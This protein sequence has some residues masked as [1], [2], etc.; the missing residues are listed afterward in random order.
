[1]I[2]TERHARLV[3]GT[4]AT[5]T[6]IT[7]WRTTVVPERTRRLGRLG[8]LLFCIVIS[9]G[10]LVAEATHGSMELVCVPPIGLDIKLDSNH[11]ALVFHLWASPLSVLKRNE[12][13]RA[14]ASRCSSP[15]KCDTGDGTVTFRH[16]NL[17]KKAT[18]TYDLKFSGSD[19]ERGAFSVLRK[20]QKKPFMCQ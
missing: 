1:M 5:E 8:Q 11:A 10:P 14:T 7:D 2:R 19:V 13:L 20:E 3:P 16:L 6:S 9:A 4:N 17:A 18:G 12:P 15:S